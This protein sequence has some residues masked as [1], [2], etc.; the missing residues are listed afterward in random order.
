MRRRRS[1]G[2]GTGHGGGLMACCQVRSDK[3]GWFELNNDAPRSV[4][5]KNTKLVGKNINVSS[6]EVLDYPGA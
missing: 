6:V 2:N 1:G 5:E 3:C 4:N